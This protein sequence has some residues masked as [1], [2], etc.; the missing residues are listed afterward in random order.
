M[1]IMRLLRNQMDRTKD[2]FPMI[3][4]QSMELVVFMIQREDYMKES[5]WMASLQVKEGWSRQMEKYMLEALMME[6]SMGKDIF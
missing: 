2:K 3:N 5:L 4:Q 1:E 6:P